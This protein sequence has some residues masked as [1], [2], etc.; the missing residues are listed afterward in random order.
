LAAL[1]SDHHL[2]FEALSESTVSAD[3]PSE[4]EDL[5]VAALADWVDFFY[6]PEPK[7]LI[8]YADHD[9]YT[10]LF[11]G[12]KGPLSQIAAGMRVAGFTEVTDYVREL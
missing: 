11:A 2:A 4:C 6:L 5:L 9:E 7:Q 1:L 3:N 8:I 12:R 10:T